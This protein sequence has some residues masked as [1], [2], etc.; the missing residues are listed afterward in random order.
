MIAAATGL[1]DS[2]ALIGAKRCPAHFGATPSTIS[3]GRART[4]LA[5]KPAGR[6]PSTHFRWRPRQRSGRGRGCHQQRRGQQWFA[7]RPGIDP[8]SLATMCAV[9]SLGKICQG[10][11]ER[12]LMHVIALPA[13][14][15]TVVPPTASPVPAT[16][17]PVPVSS[18]P[19]STSVLAPPHLLRLELTQLRLNQRVPGSS[20]GAPTTQ[21]SET[22]N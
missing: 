19:M 14:P 20:P 16:P 15:V 12:Y 4:L 5:T 17:A 21:S 11:A 22:R 7:F 6:L 9:S 13:A 18:T 2:S 1:A 10:T 8:A 3:G